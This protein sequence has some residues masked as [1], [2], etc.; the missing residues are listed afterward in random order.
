MLPHSPRRGDNLLA[1]A[2]RETSS[3]NIC[4]AL[5]VPPRASVPKPA[6]GSLHTQLVPRRAANRQAPGRF[7]RD[8]DAWSRREWQAE[9]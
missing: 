8:R 1:R 7:A 9:P 6:A 3:A 4:S 2:L 5:P